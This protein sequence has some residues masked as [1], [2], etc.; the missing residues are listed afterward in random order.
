MKIIEPK[1]E[2][3]ADSLFG[4]RKRFREVL[5]IEAADIGRAL[6]HYLGFEHR[7]LT[8]QRQHIGRRIV[9]Y[10]GG[11]HRCAASWFGCPWSCW[12]FHT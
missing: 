10:S 5:E 7:T 8:L 9:Q 4:P 2:E 12:V 6:Q 3:T 1:A 11:T